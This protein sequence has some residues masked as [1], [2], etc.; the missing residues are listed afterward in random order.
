VEGGIRRLASP[1]S[2]T[3]AYQKHPLRPLTPDAHGYVDDN[4]VDRVRLKPHISS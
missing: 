1:E 3:V 2:A 4:A